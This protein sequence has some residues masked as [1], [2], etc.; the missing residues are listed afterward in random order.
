MLRLLGRH[1][2]L[3]TIAG[4]GNGIGA[5][6]HTARVEPAGFVPAFLRPH[7]ARVWF[8]DDPKFDLVHRAKVVPCSGA[9]AAQ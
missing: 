6:E 4:M 3:E 2:V 8:D 5:D 1:A 9:P 7:V